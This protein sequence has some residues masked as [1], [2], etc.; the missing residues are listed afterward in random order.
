MKDYLETLRS[1]PEQTRRRIA[2]GGAA[3]FTAIVAIGWFIAL[4]SSGALSLSSPESSARVETAF[5]ENMGR[6]DDLAG[7]ASA[8]YANV[9]SGAS[10]SIVEDESSST[11]DRTE[12]TEPE[13]TVIPF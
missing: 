13:A 4:S 7:A 1:K 12:A 6:Y 5:T 2:L 11:L 3:G 10:I 9:Q 8:M